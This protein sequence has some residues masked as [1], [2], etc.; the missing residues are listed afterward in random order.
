MKRGIKIIRNRV[1]CKNCGEVI[2]SRHVHEFVGCSCYN[3]SGGRKGIA[4]DGGTEYLKRSGDLDGYEDMSET[5]LY[6]DKER[7]EYNEQMAALAE[8]YSDLILDFM[9]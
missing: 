5:R 1:K 9:E 2:E 4:V 8:Q 7:D 3:E 6:T